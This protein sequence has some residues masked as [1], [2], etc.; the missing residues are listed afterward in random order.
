ME[1]QRA[2]RLNW[3]IFGRI[4][5]A[6]YSRKHWAKMLL[7]AK[8][9]STSCVQSKQTNEL[10]QNIGVPHTQASGTEQP[11]GLSD[12]SNFTKGPSF[13]EKSQTILFL[14]ILLLKKNSHYFQNNK[15]FI[16]PIIN[17]MP[18]V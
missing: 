13:L 6:E 2:A 9:V 17:S 4:K 8:V 5:C 1:E 16:F 10:S 18:K 3:A 14:K 7:K 11:T 15:V 12:G